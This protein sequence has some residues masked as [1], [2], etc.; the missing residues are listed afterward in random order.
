M[1]IVIPTEEMLSKAIYLSYSYDITI[2][3]SIFV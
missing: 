2:Y 1:H 3:D